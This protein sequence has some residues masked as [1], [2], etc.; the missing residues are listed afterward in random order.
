MTQDEYRS[1][2]DST[3][4]KLMETNGN[5]V[6]LL[7]TGCSPQDPCSA[8]SH[9]YDIMKPCFDAWKNILLQIKVEYNDEDYIEIRPEDFID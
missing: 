3:Y 2:F 6:K 7:E 4:H 5:I 1:L 8:I 9:A